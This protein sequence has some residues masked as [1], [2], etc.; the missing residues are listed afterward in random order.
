MFDKIIY[1]IVFHIL[2]ILYSQ[3]ITLGSFFIGQARK[4]GNF[5]KKKLSWYMN[6]GYQIGLK[7]PIY[8]SGKY[9]SS[10]KIDIIISNHIHSYDLFLQTSIINQLSKKNIYYVFKKVC[11]FIPGLG[12][13]LC[14]APD[15][16][17]NKQM[18]YDL[19]NLVTSIKKMKS[20]I[21]VILPEGTRFTPE[22]RVL[23]QKYSRDNNLPIFN[24]T[25]FPKMKGM[26]LIC[27]ILTQE[28]RMGNIIDLT[29]MVENCKNQKVVFKN[30]ITKDIGNTLCVI[31]SYNVPPLQIIQDYD[32][33]KKWF[34]DIWKI[35]DNILE[36]MHTVNDTHIY[37]R[38]P[39]NINIKDL[40]VLLVVIIL[41]TYLMIKT[42][43]KYL[44]YSFIVSYI[45]T[46]I[47]YKLL[48]K[49]L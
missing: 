45:I 23:A 25:L 8:Y 14:C 3:T 48:K 21:I 20:G 2:H 39:S 22:K 19:D 29:T 4:G 34:L 1:S 27:N 13:N 42:N 47:R 31:N 33:F 37:T 16:K 41:F 9:E 5:S 49:K 43:G 7:S 17:L 32:V 10:D 6:T 36:N 30:L 44:G 28:N 38:L 18:E 46:I 35:K 15:I 11:I 12:F 40:S 26:W 24:N